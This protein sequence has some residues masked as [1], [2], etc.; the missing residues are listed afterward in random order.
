MRDPREYRVTSTSATSA[1][2]EDQVIGLD[3]DDSDLQTRKIVR[4]QIVRRPGEEQN[5]I[6]IT[7]K[8]VQDQQFY[9]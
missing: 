9:Y 8:S 3:E 1:N 2:I 4:I 7:M 5:L 6:K